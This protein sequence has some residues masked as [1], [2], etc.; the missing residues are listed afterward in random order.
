M[1][2]SVISVYVKNKIIP[3][4]RTVGG[5]IKTIRVPQTY[6]KMSRFNRVKP[7]IQE[8]C[9]PLIFAKQTFLILKTV[10][11]VIWTNEVP[12]RQ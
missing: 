12:Y 11:D 4:L 1:Y 6:K 7:K 2:T 8:I 9:T 10:G 3:Q 5:V